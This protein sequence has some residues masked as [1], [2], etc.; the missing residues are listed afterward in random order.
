MGVK[1][2]PDFEYRKREGSRQREPPNP[3]GL[4]LV[5]MVVQNTG[6]SYQFTI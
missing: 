5:V 3:A 2:G 6:L 1:A 4:V